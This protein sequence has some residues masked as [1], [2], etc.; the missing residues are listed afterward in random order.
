MA[1]RMS[2]ISVVCSRVGVMAMVRRLVFSCG[3]IW[4][5]IGTLLMCLIIICGMR[6]ERA[7]IDLD[8]VVGVEEGEVL[9]LLGRRGITRLL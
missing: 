7:D 2:L 5:E 8:G 4:M 6:K 3:A 1:M 9:L